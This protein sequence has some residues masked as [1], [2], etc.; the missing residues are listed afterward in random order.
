[1]NEQYSYLGVLGRN[2]ARY[3]NAGGLDTR[4]KVGVE[5]AT[6]TVRLNKASDD[7]PLLVLA[8]QRT[9]LIIA[10]AERDGAGTRRWA[11]E[12]EDRHWIRSRH[13]PSTDRL[14]G[15][16]SR[17]CRVPTAVYMATLQTF[18]K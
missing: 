12:V 10:R 1:M 15:L 17:S 14:D 6:S 7:E 16:E 5:R 8:A 2:R 13:Y 9:P 11:V 4:V 3:F 18:L